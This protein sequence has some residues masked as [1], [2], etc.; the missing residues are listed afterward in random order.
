[1]AV[2]FFHC[3]DGID[4]VLDEKGQ[5]AS[6]ADEMAAHARAV[7][8]RLMRALPGYNEWWNWSV[9]VCDEH[10]AVEI[11]DFPADRRRAA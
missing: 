6:G 4:L 1:M 10:G 9:H 2:H 3:T 8:A 5:E 7:A 11:F